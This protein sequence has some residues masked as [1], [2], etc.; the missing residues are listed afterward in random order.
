MDGAALQALA[1]DA[2]G[3]F[4]PPRAAEVIAGADVTVE[5][6]A[7]AW[8]RGAG[9]VR[10]TVVRLWVDAHTLGSLRASPAVAEA[11]YAAFAHA[12]AAQPGEG[13]AD[14]SVVW[15]GAVTREG[16][17]YRGVRLHEAGASIGEAL[18][19]YL[20]A[21]G[22]AEAAEAVHGSTD[23]TDGHDITLSS[24]VVPLPRT[25]TA[26]LDAARALL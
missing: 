8:T 7:L 13:M 14:L 20:S 15:N 17:A 12:M 9:T 1:L 21:A 26:V 5:P 25:R 6:A 11:I 24:T 4:D 23:T 10:G 3:A 22:E 2:L 19:A 16:E 18:W